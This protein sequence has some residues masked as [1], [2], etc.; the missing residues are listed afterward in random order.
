[1]PR[2]LGLLAIS[3]F[4]FLVFRVEVSHVLVFLV[5]TK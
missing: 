4:Y 3:Q 1:V 5:P 2:G